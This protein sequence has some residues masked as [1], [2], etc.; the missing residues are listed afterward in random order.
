MMG[1]GGGGSGRSAGREQSGSTTIQPYSE[2]PNNFLEKL[3][4]R[5]EDYVEIDISTEGGALRINIEGDDKT[6]PE[7]GSGE[8][9]LEHSGFAI[10][11]KLKGAVFL[12]PTSK[13]ISQLKE[14]FIDRVYD[15]KKVGFLG[16]ANKSETVIKKIINYEKDPDKTVSKAISAGLGSN[17]LGAKVKAYVHKSELENVKKRLVFQEYSEN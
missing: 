5:E 11:E 2:T 13:E 6:D 17:S 3:P 10:N 4:G 8:Y 12:E 9:L 14:K 15:L 1:K 16:S 7:K